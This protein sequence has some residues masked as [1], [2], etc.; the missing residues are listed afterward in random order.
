LRKRDVAAF[1]MEPISLNLGV[2]IPE[3]DFMDALQ[4]MCRKYGTLLVADEVASGFGRTGRMFACEHYGLE[5]DIL[6]FAKAATG[7]YAGI[8]GT[9][10]TEK[11]ARVLRTVHSIPMG[12]FNPA[13]PGLRVHLVPCHPAEKPNRLV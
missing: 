13:T 11:I 7:G 2:L 8:G 12:G 10:T 5:P 6:C 9:M 4:G 3:P 1:I